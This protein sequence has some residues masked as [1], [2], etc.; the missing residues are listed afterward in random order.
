MAILSYFGQFGLFLPFWYILAV[1]LDFLAVLGNFGL[2]W[3]FWTIF[4]VW[5]IFSFLGHLLFW[6]NFAVL[7]MLI[8]L[9]LIW[10]FQAIFSVLGYVGC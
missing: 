8:C 9:G 2:F 6:P 1:V 3:L 4:V 10:W 7:D 5:T